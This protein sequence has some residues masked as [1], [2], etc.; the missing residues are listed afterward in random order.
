MGAWGLPRGVDAPVNLRQENSEWRKGR[1]SG[2]GGFIY[3]GNRRR[4]HG[5]GFGYGK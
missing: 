3:F 1:R 5:G 4:H 2:V